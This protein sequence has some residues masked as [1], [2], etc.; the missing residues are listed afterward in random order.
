MSANNKVGKILA[1]WAGPVAGAT[2]WF[3][4]AAAGLIVAVLAMFEVVTSQMLSPVQFP[5]IAL[6]ILNQ[7]HYGRDDMVITTS[8]MVMVAGILLTQLCGWLLVRK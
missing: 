4:L 5:A 1:M 2:I 3:A 8:L 7:M 6:S